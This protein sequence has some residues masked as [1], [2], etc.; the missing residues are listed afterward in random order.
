MSWNYRVIKRF[1]EPPFEADAYYG[2]I[3]VHYDESGKHH[4]WTESLSTPV[5]Q[6]VDELKSSLTKMLAGCDKP[7]MEEVDGKLVEQP[8]PQPRAAT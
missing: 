8:H 7:V 6:N 3:E 5:D 2:I 1:N 4:S